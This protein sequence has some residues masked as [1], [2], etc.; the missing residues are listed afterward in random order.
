MLIDNTKIIKALN[1][2]AWFIRAPTVSVD[3]LSAT[4]NLQQL[5]QII[6][7]LETQHTEVMDGADMKVE[8]NASRK[9]FYVIWYAPNPYYRKEEEQSYQ[10]PEYYVREFDNLADAVVYYWQHRERGIESARLVKDLSGESLN[11]AWE[12]AQP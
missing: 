6:K 10:P 1:I 4:K 8:A 2:I 3:E 5:E 9:K 11:K 12:E 7:D